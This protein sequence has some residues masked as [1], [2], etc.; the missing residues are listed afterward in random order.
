[1]GAAKNTSEYLWCE[2][3]PVWGYVGI[4]SAQSSFSSYYSAIQR[5]TVLQLHY[6]VD[7]TKV[8]E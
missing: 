5:S 4:E 8:G 1:M 3:W 2:R 7:H 6:V